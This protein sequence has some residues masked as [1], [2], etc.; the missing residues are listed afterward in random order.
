[1]KGHYTMTKTPKQRLAAYF[2]A[3]PERTASNRRL[4]SQAALYRP[5]AAY[6][7]ALELRRTNATLYRQYFSGLQRQTHAYYELAKQAAETLENTP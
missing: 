1:M 2:G 5:D 3:K 4:V 7:A 6:D